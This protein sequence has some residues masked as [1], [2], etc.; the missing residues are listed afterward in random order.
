MANTFGAVI[1]YVLANVGRADVGEARDLVRS[2]LVDLL[3]VDLPAEIG[4]YLSEGLVELPVGVTGSVREDGVYG[5]P[6]TL[7]TC[8]GILGM[9]DDPSLPGPQYWSWL[10]QY[11]SSDRDEF[12]Y[13]WRYG[14]ANATNNL[15]GRPTYALISG[16]QLHLRPI[17]KQGAT[18]L[19]F[20][21][22]VLMGS[23]VTDY[24]SV[25]DDTVISNPLLIPCLKAGATVLEAIRQKRTDVAQPWGE[26]FT[27]RKEELRRT[28]GA[29]VR[30]RQI[31]RKDF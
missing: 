11:T 26:V 1:D 28:V 8:T 16:N 29:F 5:L 20:G 4:G 23:V 13:L 14:P 12:Y 10:N 18:P 21:K 31:P 2:D 19:W 3:N 25:T 22:V 30:N 27:K 7:R 15:Y 17:P 6:A 24:T 9:I